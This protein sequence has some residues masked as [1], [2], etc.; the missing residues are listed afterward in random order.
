MDSV[1]GN[2]IPVFGGIFQ[3]YN[4]EDLIGYGVAILLFLGGIFMVLMIV[5][6]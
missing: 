5:W 3:S 2:G 4:I 6:G 1:F